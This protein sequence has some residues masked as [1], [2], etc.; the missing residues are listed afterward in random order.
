[1]ATPPQAQS[2]EQSATAVPSAEAPASDAAIPA[3]PSSPKGEEK[4]ERSPT[5]EEMKAIQEDIKKLRELAES[6]GRYVNTRYEVFE[7]PDPKIRGSK[8]LS[9]QQLERSK[10]TRQCMAQIFY[11]LTMMEATLTQGRVMAPPGYPDPTKQPQKP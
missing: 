1:M 4:K 7:G 6:F 8:P 3:P 10:F 2:S 5:D 11:R 9:G